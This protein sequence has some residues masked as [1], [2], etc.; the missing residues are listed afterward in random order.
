M[1]RFPNPKNNLNKLRKEIFEK[2]RQAGKTKR[3]FELTVPPAA[4]NFIFNGICILSSFAIQE[5]QNNICNPYT[6][7]EQT[8]K[9]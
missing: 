5:K 2:C 3:I 8:S 6:I 9:T 7:I 1:T 4:E